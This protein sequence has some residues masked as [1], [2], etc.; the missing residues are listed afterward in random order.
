MTKCC[1][2]TSFFLLTLTLLLLFIHL[3]HG[4]DTH[5]R[6]DIKQRRA[7]RVFDQLKEVDDTQEP[8]KTKINVDTHDKAMCTSDMPSL[9]DTLFVKKEGDNGTIVNT[10]DA[11]MDDLLSQL[12]DERGA[13][14]NVRHDLTGN[15]PT[16]KHLYTH[17]VHAFLEMSKFNTSQLVRRI[18]I[19][20]GNKMKD[21]RFSFSSPM[22]LR[23]LRRHLQR[24]LKS[25][26]IVPKSDAENRQLFDLKSDIRY[27]CDSISCDV[28][29]R[30]LSYLRLVE[31]GLLDI[32][33]VTFQC[34][35][36]DPCALT[37]STLAQCISPTNA[38]ISMPKRIVEKTL[39]TP[40]SQK[41]LS[42][43]TDV[44][45]GYPRVQLLRRQ[46]RHDTE[47]HDPEKTT[48][49]QET[50]ESDLPSRLQQDVMRETSKF[51]L[52]DQLNLENIEGM[53]TRLV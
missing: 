43:D 7:E 47:K 33:D 31:F 53:Y 24:H 48:R 36:Q 30:V 46:R 8:K 39:S 27:N 40:N 5:P 38:T 34:L 6:A 4:K 32:S 51:L 37:L 25:H 1:W 11:F 49:L 19:F 18:D 13:A 9:Y 45:A 15:S 16:Q 42:G 14:I 21:I 20:L 2:P 28:Q 44:E 29:D 3:L 22:D 26:C 23:K 52:Y 35:K 50:T 12:E 17:D 10:F 41:Q